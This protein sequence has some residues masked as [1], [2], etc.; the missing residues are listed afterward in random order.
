ML[1]RLWRK[2]NTPS[3]LVGCKLVQ[4]LLNPNFKKANSWDSATKYVHSYAQ[5]AVGKLGIIG[6]YMKR[7]NY[8]SLK[9]VEK[10]IAAEAKPQKT[11]FMQALPSIGSEVRPLSYEHMRIES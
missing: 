8:S 4:P 6:W 2:R 1:A 7:S 3:L 9:Q 5:E 11:L 10:K